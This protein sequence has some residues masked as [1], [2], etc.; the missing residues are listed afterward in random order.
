MRM[1]DNSAQSTDLPLISQRRSQLESI[2]RVMDAAASAAHLARALGVEKS[3][4][5]AL[6]EEVRDEFDSR[7][8]GMQLRENAEGWRLYTRTANA[9]PVEE[10]LLD[11]SQTKLSRAALETLAVIAYRQPVTRVQV[12]AVRGVNVDGVMRTL[13]IR[14]MI[15]EVE[16]SQ[17]PELTE[18]T[19]STARFFLDNWALILSLP[20]LILRHCCRNSTA[21]TTNFNPA[22]DYSLKDRDHR[23]R[24]PQ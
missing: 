9:A 2:V 7:G 21:L 13:A 14:G 22:D 4:V 19:S 16:A 6:L 15:R 18:E 11:G 12:S 8:S 1:D 3:E 17:H 23:D 20:C 10:F 5:V 24:K